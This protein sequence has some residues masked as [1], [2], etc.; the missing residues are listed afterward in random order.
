[1]VSGLK[2]FELRSCLASCKL[3]RSAKRS[4]TRPSAA[5]AASRSPA[6]PAPANRA[7]IFRNFSRNWDSVD[8]G[9]LAVEFEKPNILPRR[10]QPPGHR[11]PRHSF[12]VGSNDRY[13]RVA[14]MSHPIL[15]LAGAT[16]RQRTEAGSRPVGRR[17]PEA[18]VGSRPARRSGRAGDLSR[19][20]V[21]PDDYG[22]PQSS[23]Q[24]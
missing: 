6:V 13:R 16:W 20:Q 5:S 21:P 7:S 11:Y 1:M 14:N 2:L 9:R 10:G 22:S 15:W 4:R 3:F 18:V 23:G 8:I 12:A 17:N 24:R 19:D